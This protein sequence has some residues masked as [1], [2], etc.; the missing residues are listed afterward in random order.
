MQFPK[1]KRLRDKKA[2]ESA[3]KPYCE[4]CG[5]SGAGLQVHHVVT[6]G[7]GGHDHPC[8]LVCVCVDCH[9]EIHAGRI[10][11]NE[12]WPVIARRE[13]MSPM[14]VEAAARERRP[15]V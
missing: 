10:P 6:R 8:N 2:I 1:Q 14:A 4:L 12:L 3:R 9:T 15:Y 13:G 5:R 7:A 11:K